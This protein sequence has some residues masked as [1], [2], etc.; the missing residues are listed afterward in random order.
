MCSGTRPNV[1]CDR[2][3]YEICRYLAHS[4]ILFMIIFVLQMQFCLRV[5]SRD[6]SD[7]TSSVQGSRRC[8]SCS[9]GTEY[10]LYILMRCDSCCLLRW[11]P[12]STKTSFGI[13][14]AEGLCLILSM[15]TSWPPR[16]G[17]FPSHYSRQILSSNAFKPYK[18]GLQLHWMATHRQQFSER[19]CD[20]WQRVSFTSR[21]ISL[22]A[23]YSC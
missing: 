20:P 2:Y 23:V 8:W 16:M 22:F 6:N 15:W 7:I 12:S 10:K 19:V 9:P 1:R 11:C 17:P 5:S 18:M 14:K 21:R 4:I 13:L 3:S